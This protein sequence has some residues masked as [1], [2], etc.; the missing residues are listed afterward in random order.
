MQEFHK[1]EKI[2]SL[3]RQRFRGEREVVLSN[4]RSRMSS[5]LREKGLKDAVGLDVKIV[6][7]IENDPKTGKFKLIIPF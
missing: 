4:I 3:S 2:G 7:E 6:D 1:L 5:I